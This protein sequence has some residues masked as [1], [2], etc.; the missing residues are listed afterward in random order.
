MTFDEMNLRYVDCASCENCKY[1]E[2]GICKLVNKEIPFTY[3]S[4]VVCDKW[5]DAEEV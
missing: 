1:E 5:E 4:E 2:R 3:P